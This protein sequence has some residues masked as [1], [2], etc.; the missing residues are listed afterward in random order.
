MN[1]YLTKKNVVV[2]ILGPQ[3]VAWLPCALYQS[4]MISSRSLPNLQL[5]PPLVGHQLYVFNI[6]VDVIR[7]Y[8]V[9]RN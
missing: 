9:Y 5:K 2:R 4:L 1:Y 7:S 8:T 6:R 3:V